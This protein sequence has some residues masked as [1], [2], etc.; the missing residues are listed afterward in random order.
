MALSFT[1][2]LFAAILP[3]RRFEALEADS[4]L[5]L[6]RC[7][8]GLARSVWELGGIRYKAA[9]EPR[10]FMKCPQCG[11]RSWH[12]VSRDPPSNTPSLKT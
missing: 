9:G 5:W 6:A 3:R 1:Q 10:W 11:N 4:R 7:S 8:C 2:K 12:Q